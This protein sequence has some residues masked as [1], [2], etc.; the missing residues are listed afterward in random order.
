MTRR[1]W[2]D[3]QTATLVRLYPTHTAHQISEIVGWSAK[4]VW[5]KAARLGLGLHRPAE[6]AGGDEDRPVDVVDDVGVGHDGAGCHEEAGADGEHDT[7][8]Q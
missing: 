5:M 3:E 1:F 6:M 8:R 7:N 4:A 2:T